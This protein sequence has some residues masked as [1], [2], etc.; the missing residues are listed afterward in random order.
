MGNPAVVF[1][2]FGAAATTNVS[3]HANSTSF[4]EL[5][6]D[7]VPRAAL[8]S[9]GD[10]TVSDFDTIR[11]V[12]TENSIASNGTV[13]GTHID[14]VYTTRGTLGT[15]ALSGGQYELCEFDTGAKGSSIADHVSKSGVSHNY[16]AFANTGDGDGLTHL[17]SGVLNVPASEAVGPPTPYAPDIP[18]ANIEYDVAHTSTPL[19]AIAG[20]GTR[21]ALSIPLG[22]GPD[23]WRVYVA[24]LIKTP[25]EGSD[26]VS[27]TRTW[28]INNTGARTQTNN[29]RS[30]RISEL[31]SPADGEPGLPYG[32]TRT[33]VNTTSA[34][35][36]NW[37]PQASYSPS[38]TSAAVHQGNIKFR[39]H[40][41]SEY[42][43]TENMTTTNVAVASVTIAPSGDIG[44]IATHSKV[45]VTT[46]S[47]HGLTDEQNQIVMSGSDNPTHINGIHNVHSVTSDTIFT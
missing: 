40:P 41:D 26:P 4:V 38:T 29:T 1:T 17:A 7:L 6:S 14:T 33:Y 25:V 23:Y 2:T 20:G 28:T 45:T 46:D 9:N 22:S 47:V 24:S 36:E 35:M 13:T 8:F 10:Y 34:I 21:E 42:V 39:V 15:F 12:T 18:F 32:I 30:L 3:G 37:F 19:Q 11:T 27:Y 16:V 44:P 43:M 5:K 31:V